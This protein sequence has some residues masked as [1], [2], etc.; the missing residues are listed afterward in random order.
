MP[1][2]PTTG[3]FTLSLDL[4]FSRIPLKVSSLAFSANVN[5]FETDEW[6]LAVIGA[7][8]DLNLDISSR[9][10]F[11]AL[12]IASDTIPVSPISLPSS[13][14]YILAIFESERCFI[15]FGSIVPPPPPTK[16]TCS[17]PA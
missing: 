4:I 10:F 17:K 16:H 8:S 9:L 5:N 12:P 7:L 15:S 3:Q 14:E 13:G 2:K 6:S 1:V 11:F